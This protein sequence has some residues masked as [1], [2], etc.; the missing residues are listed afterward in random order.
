MQIRKRLY[1]MALRAIHCMAGARNSSKRNPL[2]LE[3]HETF[4]GQICHPN[5]PCARLESL[6]SSTTGPKKIIHIYIYIY[7]GPVHYLRSGT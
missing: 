1:V 4:Y 6:S 7:I 2:L 5:G 3:I